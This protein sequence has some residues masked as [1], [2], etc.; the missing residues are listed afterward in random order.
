MLNSQMI[1]NGVNR[2]WPSVYDEEE[3][4]FQQE[5]GECDVEEHVLDF[6]KSPKVVTKPESSGRRWCR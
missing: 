5:K 6:P 4:L 3:S 1:G 2:A